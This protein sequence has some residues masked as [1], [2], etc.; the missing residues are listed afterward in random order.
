MKIEESFKDLKSLLGIDKVMCQKRHWMEQMVC[1]AFI[2]YAIGLVLGETLRSHLFPET[3][4]KHKLYS[5]LF[6]LLKLKLAVDFMEFRRI[7]KTALQ[8][9]QSII[10]PV[11]TPV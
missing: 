8:A 9:F 2:A 10:I 6:V 4:R 7:C 3:S 5:G 1:L 11:R